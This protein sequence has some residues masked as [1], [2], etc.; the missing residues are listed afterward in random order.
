MD[1]T[2]VAFDEYDAP[3]KKYEIAH[4]LVNGTFML[5]SDEHPISKPS[6]TISVISSGISNLTKALQF[7]NAWYPIEVTDSPIVI[8]VIKEQ[9]SKA[10]IEFGL[11]QRRYGK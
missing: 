10:I 5:W 2:S 3:P 9:L 8:S 4:E 1:G 7:S 6:K 11:R